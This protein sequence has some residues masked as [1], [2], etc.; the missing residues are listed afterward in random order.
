MLP[1]T[2]FIAY[3]HSIYYSVHFNFQVRKENQNGIIDKN[4]PRIFQAEIQTSL[5]QN[6]FAI[7]NNRY[8]GNTK[9]KKN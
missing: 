8:Q 4:R 6:T 2:Y 1:F 9:D 7:K 3:V 5:Q